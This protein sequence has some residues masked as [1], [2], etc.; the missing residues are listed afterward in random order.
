MIASIL[1]NILQAFYEPFWF[2]AVLTVF[3]SFFYMYVT[4]PVGA[5]SGIKVAFKAWLS[6]IRS[7]DT[8]RAFV[9]LTFYIVLVLFKTLFY[10]QVW[11]NP[12]QDVM[13][14]WWIWKTSPSTGEVSMTTE[15]FENVILMVPFSFLLRYF[16]SKQLSTINDNIFYGVKIT[17]FFSLSIESAQLFLRLGT[18]QFSDLFYNTFGGLLGAILYKSYNSIKIK[19]QK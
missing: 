2:A 19:A 3:V 6:Q 7:D 18:F 11:L 8:F 5:G 12:L 9:V 14:G 4:E 13:G 1:T 10:R 16:V 15:C 17:F